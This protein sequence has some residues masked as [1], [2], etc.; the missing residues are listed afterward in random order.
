MADFITETVENCLEHLSLGSLRKLQTGEYRATGKYPIIDQGQGFV[1]GWT[2][3]ERGLIS[4]CL[5]VIIFGD[6][7]RVFKYVDFPFVRGADGTQVLKPRAEIN[8]LFF[9]YA[10]RAIDLPGSGI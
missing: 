5:P 7:T 6:H 10:C 3:N 2:D 8:P 4:T 9:Y 1:A